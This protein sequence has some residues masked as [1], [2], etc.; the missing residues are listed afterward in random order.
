[1]TTKLKRRMRVQLRDS[2]NGVY[3]EFVPGGNRS[4]IWVGADVSGGYI[5][6]LDYKSKE[7]L[8]RMVDAL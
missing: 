7:K 2:S 8:K 5:G 1:M 3:M 6:I 4:Y